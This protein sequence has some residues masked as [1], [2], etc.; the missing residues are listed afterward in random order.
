[1]AY[2][3]HTISKDGVLDWTKVATVRNTSRFES[4]FGGQ[5]LDG[6]AQPVMSTVSTDQGSV[7][8][9]IDT[10][11]ALYIFDSSVGAPNNGIT[12][13]VDAQGGSPAF[14]VNNSGFKSEA[15]AIH[16]YADGSYKLAVK[17][18][19]TING[20]DTI[21]WEVYTVNAR[22]PSTNE[23]K[24][25][26]AKTAY[27]KDVRDVETFIKQDIDGDGVKGR[28]QNAVDVTGDV[29]TVK[30][31]L[32]ADGLLYV[33]NAGTKIAIVDSFGV[34]I[35]LNKSQTWDSGNSSFTAEVVAAEKVDVTTSGT[36]VSTFKIAVKETMALQ[37]ETP[38]VTWKIYT[39]SADGIVNSKP[40]VSTSIARWEAVLNQDLNVDGV[41]GIVL[42]DLTPVATDT[43]DVSLD[44]SGAVYVRSGGVFIQVTDGNDGSVSFESDESQAGSSSS[45]HVIAAETQAD[46]TILMAVEYDSQ[47]G[48]VATKSWVVHTLNVEGT[49]SSAY[50]E[51]DW[52]KADVTSDM[53]SY[54]SLFG[55]NF[56]QDQVTTVGA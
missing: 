37:N 26:W 18:T 28:D 20:T 13:I 19:I 29:G 22:D 30:A 53:S 42:S 25:D 3:I 35:N 16:Q 51:I 7:V 52:T 17:K 48:D 2:Q 23:A 33:N 5:D 31:A 14:D 11:K 45:S 36:T 47:V 9:Q 8:L 38:S 24:I 39:A 4:L 6:L 56:V 40:V 55:Q 46:G 54:V 41:K 50:A 49:G 32:T 12:Y 10:T 34:G 43:S 1:V 15:Y 21:K 27:L 44:K